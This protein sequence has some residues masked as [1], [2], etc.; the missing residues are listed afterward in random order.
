M[1]SRQQKLLKKLFFFQAITICLFL[2]AIM[3]QS[4]ETTPKPANPADVSS[5]DAII[6]A[7][8]DVIS[9][10]AGQ[11]RDWDRFQTLFY[12]EGRLIPTNKNAETKLFG[13]NPLTPEGY[14]KRVEP[15]FA[16]NGFYEKEIARKMD[17]YGNIVQA[18]ST[19]E[20]RRQKT[21]EKPFLRGINSFQ[22]LFD[23]NRW[24][25]LTIFW[26]AETPDNPIPDKYERSQ[27]EYLSSETLKGYPF[28][29]SVRVGN[30][31]YLSGQIGTDAAGKVVAG[32]IAAETK[33]ALE[34]IK[35]ALERQGSSMDNIVKCTVML[36]DFK[37]WAEMNKVY[38]TFFKNNLPAR[39]ALGASGLA[40]NARVEIECMAT[41]K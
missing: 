29:E 33:Q 5:V 35:A 21:D 23:G 18:F 28:S 7:V 9:G 14:I 4:T 1:S 34:N 13:A 10:D 26:Q 22:L 8:Y 30:V 36:A 12:K 27:T 6:K 16:Q 24:W 37:E 3:A 38:V 32:G 17:T 41:V 25:V 19:Y 20:A 40:L 11:K 39:S 15:V 2:Q 31:I